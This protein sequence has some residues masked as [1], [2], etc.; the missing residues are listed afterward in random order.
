MMRVDAAIVKNGDA[1]GG[2][3]IPAPLLVPVDIGLVVLCRPSFSS[4]RD[5]GWNKFPSQKK[6][7]GKAGGSSHMRL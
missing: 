3:H 2:F 4:L 7:T 6:S 1:K 5:R